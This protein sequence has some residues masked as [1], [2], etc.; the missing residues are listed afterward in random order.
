MASNGARVGPTNCLEKR[1]T[2][3]SVYF[4]QEFI[5]LSLIAVTTGI[6]ISALSMIFSGK[7]TPRVANAKRIAQALGMNVGK[8]L[9]ALEE[10]V[11]LL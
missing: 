5:N 8:F 1:P 2:T 3:Q 9:G 10:H 4:G 11:D 7:R 6:S